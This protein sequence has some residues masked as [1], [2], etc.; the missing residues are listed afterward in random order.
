M[1]FDAGIDLTSS[2]RSTVLNIIVLRNLFAGD[3]AVGDSSLVKDNLAV[4]NFVDGI[5]VGERGQVQDNIASLNGFDGFGDGIYAG[6]RCRITRNSAE[7]N[8]EDGIATGGSSHGVLQHA[9]AATATTASTSEPT[10]T[11]TA[12]AAS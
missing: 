9:P 1:G 3:H 2:T 5:V 12:R 11:S 10:A 8:A 6:N 7:G 4:L